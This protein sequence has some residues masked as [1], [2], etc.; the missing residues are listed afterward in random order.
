VGGSTEVRDG[1]V[2]V[3]IF[4]GLKNS[5]DD[6]ECIA[7]TELWRATLVVPDARHGMAVRQVDR[8]TTLDG[9]S[10]PLI[11]NLRA[12][13]IFPEEFPSYP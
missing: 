2:Y 10:V 3:A 1:I 7:S 9:V 13:L 5:I 4:S 8:S 11:E 12:S 6:E